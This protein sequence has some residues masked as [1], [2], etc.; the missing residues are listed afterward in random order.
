MCSSSPRAGPCRG[1]QATCQHQHSPDGEEDKANQ[2]DDAPEEDFKLLRV[3]L[4]AKVVYKGM[5]LTQAKDAKGSHVLRG[6]DRLQAGES[7]I[8]YYAE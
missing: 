2:G 1:S 4:A 5:D 7:T 3:Q 6:E 8:R